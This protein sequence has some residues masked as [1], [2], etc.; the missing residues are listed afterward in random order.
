MPK[1][2]RAIRVT[3]Y[4]FFW[5]LL[6]TNVGNA[7]W[8]ALLTFFLVGCGD[9]RAEDLPSCQ[10]FADA[11]PNNNI[12]VFVVPDPNPECSWYGAQC[13]IETIGKKHLNF[14]CEGLVN[15]D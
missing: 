11:W 9:Q 4:F 13:E 2:G 14:L 5:I 12:E 1:N 7:F 6:G 15:E 8:L 10:A 3:N